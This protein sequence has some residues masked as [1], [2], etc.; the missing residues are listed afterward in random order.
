MVMEAR[1]FQRVAALLALLAVVAYSG[2]GSNA[3]AQEET[4]RAPDL[5]GPVL[6][7]L[8]DDVLAPSLPESTVVDQ[9]PQPTFKS[10]PESNIEPTPESSIE[11]TPEPNVEPTPEA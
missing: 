7:V 4:L 11:L 6:E 2:A 9:P 3:R 10:T 8:P 5:S 1:L